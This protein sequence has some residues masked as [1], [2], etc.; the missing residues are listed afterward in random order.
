[1]V[2][3]AGRIS[4]QVRGGVADVRCGVAGIVVGAL[5]GGVGMGVNEGMR[6]GKLRRVQNGQLA[7]AKHGYG[8][9]RCNQDPLNVPFHSAQQ[10]RIRRIRQV[11]SGAVKLLAAPL[12]VKL[13]F[14]SLARLQ[15]AG[16]KAA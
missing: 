13:W 4:N 5:P 11:C 3:I 6:F 15:Q 9:E 7:A 12:I 1:M 10:S 14:P 16:P 2:G 8:N